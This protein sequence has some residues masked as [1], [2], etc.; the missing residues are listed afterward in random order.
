MDHSVITCDEKRLLLK[1]LRSLDAEKKR[2]K[3]A[4]L[5]SDAYQRWLAAHPDALLLRGLSALRQGSAGGAR[6]AVALQK[7]GGRDNGRAYYVF[8]SE[9][10]LKDYS[11][12]CRLLGTT[13][14]F[15]FESR[16]S[17]LIYAAAKQ[18][19]LSEA[20]FEEVRDAV[21]YSVGLYYEIPD[22]VTDDDSLSASFYSYTKRTAIQKASEIFGTMQNKFIY[23]DAYDFDIT[24]GDVV[25]PEEEIPGMVAAGKTASDSVSTERLTERVKAVLLSLAAGSGAQSRYDIKDSLFPMAARSRRAVVVFIRA[26]YEQ[27]KG[28][29]SAWRSVALAYQLTYAHRR[30]TGY[31]KNPAFIQACGGTSMNEML[32]EQKLLARPKTERLAIAAIGKASL[33]LREKGVLFSVLNSFAAS[34]GQIGKALSKEL[35]TSEALD[36]LSAAL[37]VASIE[38]EHREE[39]EYHE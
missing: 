23:I 36:A 19:R 35:R 30:G 14:Y 16:L 29:A 26:Y 4:V 24:G 31:L 20:A 22:A 6:G 7:A 13:A 21:E 5:D 17:P 38:A 8:E 27:L 10:Q 12:A 33:L 2:L 18:Y 9:K 15:L 11:D 39:E 34:A 32:T 3:P 28:R 25:F 37:A 1:E